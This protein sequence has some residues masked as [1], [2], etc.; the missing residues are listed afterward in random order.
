M[1]IRC[2]KFTPLVKGA[3]QGFADLLLDSGLTL[4]DCT[5]MESNGRRWLGLPSKPQLDAGKNVKRAADG[6]VAY[7]PCVSIGDRKRRDAFNEQALEAIDSFRGI[8]GM[9][10]A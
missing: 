9:R 10:T 5:V 4:H 7:T 2:L 1:T 3:L 6:K 8:A